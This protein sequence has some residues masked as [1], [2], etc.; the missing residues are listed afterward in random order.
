M[1]QKIL[2]VV[3]GGVVQDVLVANPAGVTVEVLDRDNLESVAGCTS[4]Q[5]DALHDRLSAGLF[6]IAFELTEQR[7]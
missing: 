2:V 4:R 5:C 6:H 1:A 7:Q 3:S